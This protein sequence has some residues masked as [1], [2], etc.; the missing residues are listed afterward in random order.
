VRRGLSPSARQSAHCSNG[1]WGN[2]IGRPGSGAPHDAHVA[3]RSEHIEDDPFD[4]QTLAKV[5]HDTGRGIEAGLGRAGLDA[6]ELGQQRV[7]A[8][9]ESFEDGTS[10]AS[11]TN[12]RV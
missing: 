10:G 8:F 5:T 9:F 6:F 4:R 12:R 1:A 7:R 11:A 2:R 3:F